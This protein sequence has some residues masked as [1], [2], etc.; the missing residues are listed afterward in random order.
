MFAKVETLQPGRARRR[1]HGHHA[2]VLILPDHQEQYTGSDSDKL[3]K[4]AFRFENVYTSTAIVLVT[5]HKNKPK[6][7]YL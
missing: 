1:C 6:F 3:L 2:A 7:L 5:F 4:K